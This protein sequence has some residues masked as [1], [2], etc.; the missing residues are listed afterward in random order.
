MK[1]KVLLN[2]SCAS[3]TFLPFLTTNKEFNKRYEIE[4]LKLVFML[5]E[6]DLKEYFEKIKNCDILITQPI[7]GEVYKKMGTDT[8]TVK[9]L[10]KDGAR[11]IKMPMPYFRGYYPE[12]FYIHDENGAIVNDCG[13]LPAPYHNKIIFWGFINN[14]TSD[15][16]LNL[17]MAKKNMKNISKIAQDSIKEMQSREIGLDFKIS[18][19]IE[20]NYKEKRLF[21]SINH[22]TNLMIR[23]MTK[24]I[25][26]L[27][28]IKKPFF[29]FERKYVKFLKDE[30]LGFYKT[31]IIPSV[32]SELKIKLFDKEDEKY[33][34]D[35]IEK[36]CAFYKTRPDLI[37]LNK[38]Q[39]EDLF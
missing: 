15:E 37:E 1:Q 3:A 35:F 39:V 13:E 11:L 32:R 5:T 19:F 4:N 28:G 18:D 24:E 7:M 23:H 30:F 17:L 14:K 34:L 36:A 10:M 31:P 6:D 29:Q 25:L 12:Q 9:S 2:G 33:T 16:I 27:L 38:A 26:K 21:W 8:E 22:P 20:K